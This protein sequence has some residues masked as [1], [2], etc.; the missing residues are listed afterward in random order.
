MIALLCLATFFAGCA[1]T[2]EKEAQTGPPLYT[3]YN[4]WKYDNPRHMYC[5]NFKSAPEIIPAGTRVYDAKIVSKK[6]KA[7]TGTTAKNIHFKIADTGEKILIKMRRTWHPDVTMEDYL[8]RMITSQTFEEMTAGFSIDEIEAIKRGKI[9]AGM[10]KKAVLVSFGY[11]PEH[12]TESL[13]KD[14]WIY[15]IT[16]RQQKKICFDEYDRAIQCGLGW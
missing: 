4:I 10:H 13:D 6:T 14:E 5:M 11:P 16:T 8:N 7:D 2:P 1:K 12:R 15:W 9:I 3:A